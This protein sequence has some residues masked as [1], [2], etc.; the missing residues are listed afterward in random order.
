MKLAIS[1]IGF[2]IDKTD[3]IYELLNKY[4]YSAIEIAPSIF[5]GE[6]P[7]EN[8]VK[9]RNLKDNLKQEYNLDIASMQSIW[10]GKQG[11]IFINEQALP[12]IDYTKKAIEFANN[13]NIKNIVFGC[14]KNR[15]I[16]KGQTA[17]NA[18]WFFSEIADFAVQN[19]T[20]IALEANPEIY[21]TNFCNTSESV[22]NYVKKVPNLKV[23]YDF[24]AFIQNGESLDVLKQN[25]KLVN[26]VHIS[27]PFLAP[28][29]MQNQ[30]K[31]AHVELADI[32]RSENY[33]GYVSIEMKSQNIDALQEILKYISQVFA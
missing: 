9:A 21:G 25:I 19:G 20:F 13:L 27:E 3:K 26:H 22:F 32:L 1:N 16:Q 17:D 15:N 23:N 31:N 28:I 12:L 6:N 24:G 14:P 7:Y 29:C 18:L 30:R 8:I 11:N 5:A 4:N 10:F 33:T 2:E